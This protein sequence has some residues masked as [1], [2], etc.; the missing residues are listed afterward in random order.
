VPPEVIN[1]VGGSSL[2]GASLNAPPTGF[3]DPELG[4]YFSQKAEIDTRTPTRAIPGATGSGTASRTPI[5]LAGSAIAGISVGGAVLIGSIIVGACLCIRRRRSIKGLPLSSQP[6]SSTTKALPRVPVP[7][8]YLGPER[9]YSHPHQQKPLSTPSLHS[10]HQL[11]TTPEPAEL[12]GSYYQG[13]AEYVKEGGLPME[14]INEN[15]HPAYQTS[16]SPSSPQVY[17]S[18]SPNRSGF[19]VRNS[20]HSNK[21]RETYGPS[22]ISAGPTVTTIGRTPTG[23]RSP[24]PVNDFYKI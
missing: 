1:I 16:K 24:R 4:V 23:D 20:I 13:D 7:Q 6:I 2:G 18:N 11:A 10:S 17:T 9:T 15:D 8:E 22:P 3:Q 14:Q 12:H 5:K 21:N 19:S